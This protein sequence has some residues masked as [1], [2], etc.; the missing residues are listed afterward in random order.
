MARD[1]HTDAP[2]CDLTAGFAVQ[3]GMSVNRVLVL[4]R[5]KSP[6]L[7]HEKSAKIGLIQHVQSV[8]SQPLLRVQERDL[9][10]LSPDGAM[11]TNRWF[12]VREQ[13]VEEFERGTLSAWDQFETGTN[14]GVVGLWKTEPNDG[15]VSYFLIARYADFATWEES[16]FYNRPNDDQDTDW[17]EKFRKRRAHMVD[18]SV[19]ATRC[20]FGPV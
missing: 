10:L 4:M 17:A 20:L 5:S 2:D 3:I 13:G 18:T 14:S 7:L 1:A 6:A 9:A 12:H 19:T 16:R 8:A 11:Y 15:I